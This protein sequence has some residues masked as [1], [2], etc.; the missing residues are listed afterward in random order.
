[1]RQ[2]F[3]QFYIKG[4][5]III[6]IWYKKRWRQEM[7]CSNCGNKMEDGSVFCGN[8][9]TKVGVASEVS[10]QTASPVQPTVNGGGKSKVAAG[11]L[12]ILLGCG[13]HNLYLGYTTKGIIQLVLA[14]VGWVLSFI[15]VGLLLVL[16]IWIWC[17][18]EGIKCF[19]GTYK[20]AKGYDLVG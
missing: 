18:V 13:I 10:P 6:H 19:T 16:G 7:F 2:F 11:L 5:T 8:C 4:L 12:A 9:G 17:L 15:F 14:I 3:E 1:M 20:D